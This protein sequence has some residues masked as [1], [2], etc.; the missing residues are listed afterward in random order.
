[1]LAAARRRAKSVNV[2]VDLLLGNAGNLPFP[3]GHFDCVVSV[4]TLCIVHDPVPTVREMVRV[5]TPG[6]RLIV[7][8]LGRWYFWEKTVQLTVQVA[9][10]YVAFFDFW[11]A[12]SSV[13]EPSPIRRLPGSQPA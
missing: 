8:E 7:G 10:S 9:A 3:T 6:G 12:P 5:L 1:M 4:A 2:E 13:R 11:C